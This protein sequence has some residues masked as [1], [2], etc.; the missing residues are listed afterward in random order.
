MNSMLSKKKPVYSLRGVC[1]FVSKKIKT[2]WLSFSTAMFLL[3]RIPCNFLGSDF[4][5]YLNHSSRYFAFVGIFLGVLS[6]FAFVGLSQVF[7]REIATIL[8]IAFFLMLNGAF[9]I[10]G[11]GDAFDGLGGGHT[12]EDCMRI[13]KDSRVGNY[14][15]IGIWFV[16]MLTY[17]AL[18]ALPVH[19]VFLALVVGH[20][21]S[22]G[23]M[24]III[25][26][27]PHAEYSVENTPKIMVSKVSRLDMILGIVFGAMPLLFFKD[28]AVFWVVL[29]VVVVT[30]WLG[31]YFH[32]RI[33]GYTGDCLGLQQQVCEVLIYLFFSV[34]PWMSV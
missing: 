28:V 18:M 9:H 13:M 20:S 8:T 10:D 1:N 27:Y 30:L 15:V 33:Q 24:N 17:L 25:Q 29:P 14:G 3:S 5:R 26:R 4:T 16:L 12:T 21:L 22:R 7:S 19:K 11:V 32:Q 34:Y 31:R 2:E 23:C 6:G